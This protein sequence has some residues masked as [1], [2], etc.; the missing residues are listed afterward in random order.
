MTKFDGKILTYTALSLILAPPFSTALAEKKEPAATAKTAP[1]A[2]PAASTPGSASID[3]ITASTEERK[4]LT[5][6]QQKIVHEAREA[7]SEI[8]Q[9]LVALDNKDTK[10][11]LSTLK[12]ASTNLN[13]VL[14]KNP[15][16]ALIPVDVDVDIIDFEGDNNTVSKAISE[17]KK[18]LDDGQL[19]GA[20]KILTVLASE[21]RITTENIPLGTFP[22]AVK[23]AV[24]AIEAGKS[25]DAIRILND[26]LSAIAE[27][28]DILPLPILRAE[29]LLTEAAILEHTQDLSKD[30][31]REAVL[32]F[33]EASKNQ[34]KLAELLGYGGKDD[35]QL[36]YTA[37]DE[38][39]DVISTEKSAATWDKIKKKFADL[40]NKIMPSKN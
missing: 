10:T 31:S 6:K 29:A 16:M 23:D 5:E 28:V 8:G 40:K 18:L 21:M 30:K 33:A 12:S 11:A 32:K 19:Q 1:V 36:L 14:S 26:A 38:I 15:G 2:T 34:L 27:T 9:A 7:V 4:I 13:T 20:R 22:Q 17:A 25:V 24:K 3:K 37:I 35:Y 39:K